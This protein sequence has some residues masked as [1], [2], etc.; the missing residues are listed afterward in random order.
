MAVS[1]RSLSSC[2]VPH[3]WPH[4]QPYI[5]HQKIYTGISWMAFWGRS[6]QFETKCVYLLFSSPHTHTHTHTHI[7]LLEHLRT[8]FQPLL[9]C[10]VA[11][12]YFLILLL[13]EYL[14]SVTD[15]SCP[16]SLQCLAGRSA[17]SLSS[18][19]EPPSGF[20]NC[21]HPFLLFLSLSWSFFSFLHAEQPR[22]PVSAGGGFV[23]D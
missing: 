10:W 18:M 13:R 19:S 8:N 2:T 14:L 9:T 23:K 1:P 3:L 7:E 4:I 17:L 16:R 12:P 15:C 21:S 22:L 20:G 5:P 11:I 6:V